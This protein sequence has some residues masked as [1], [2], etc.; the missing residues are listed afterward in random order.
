MDRNVE[1]RQVR[2]QVARE[3]PLHRIRI[4]DVGGTVAQ[5]MHRF[6]LNDIHQRVA[7]QILRP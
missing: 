4:N 1:R 7:D 5:I 3:D 2:T 6:A